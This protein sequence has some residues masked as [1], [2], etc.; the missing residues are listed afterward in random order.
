MQEALKRKFLFVKSNK[1]IQT[2]YGFNETN[3][4]KLIEF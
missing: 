3:I 1:S 2:S 4:S